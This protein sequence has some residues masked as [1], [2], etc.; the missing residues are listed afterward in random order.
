M[1]FIKLTFKCKENSEYPNNLY[2][3]F[4][5]DYLNCLYKN[6]QIESDY[7]LIKKDNLY[8][9]FVTSVDVDSLDEKFSNEH[10][11]ELKEKL[12]CAI[13]SEVLGTSEFSDELCNCTSKSG[14]ILLYSFISNGSPVRCIDCWRDVPLYKLPHILQQNDYNDEM[15]WARSV[16]ITEELWENGVNQSFNRKQMISTKS[17]LY[18]KGKELCREFEK[19]TGKP[20]YYYL[21]D[22]DILPKRNLLK[23]CPE[24]GNK[25]REYKKSFASGNVL[26]INFCDEC[27]LASSKN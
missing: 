1:N 18:R 6:G 21:A 9:A 15:L 13:D 25:W 5:S 24:C 16:R 14:Y 22:P 8:C 2:G 17:E 4:I 10:I 11:K 7:S 12:G 20:F 23:K 19:A 26:E 3:F 27:R